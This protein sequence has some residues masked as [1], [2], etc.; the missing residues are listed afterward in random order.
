MMLS[1]DRLSKVVGNL[2][3]APSLF[4]SNWMRSRSHNFVKFIT[5]IER[6]PS[7]TDFRQ[8]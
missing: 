8:S 6:E 5:G 4:T 3:F 2:L 7:R 1:L